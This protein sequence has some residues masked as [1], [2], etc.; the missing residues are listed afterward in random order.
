MEETHEQ[1][2]DEGAGGVPAGTAPAGGACPVR[3]GSPP[4]ECGDLGLSGVSLGVAA[5]RVPAA[6][7]QADRAAAEGIASS[8]REELVVTRPEAFARQSAAAVTH[9]LGRRL[10]GSPRE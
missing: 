8:S 4:G 3:G 9:A 2:C 5:A 6:A 1:G 7:A 10:F